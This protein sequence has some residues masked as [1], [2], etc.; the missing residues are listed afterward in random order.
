MSCSSRSSSSSER[1]IRVR[2]AISAAKP[3]PVFTTGTIALPVRSPAYK[4]ASALYM[5]M[6]AAFS[7]FRHAFSEAW[8]SETTYRRTVSFPTRLFRWDLP[9]HHRHVD[10]LRPSPKRLDRVHDD[11]EAEEDQRERDAR[12]VQV[13]ERRLLAR[14]ERV[15]DRLEPG[16]PEQNADEHRPHD[17]EYRKPG[18]PGR[19]PEQVP[20]RE[21]ADEGVDP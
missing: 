19:V 11:G 20:A 16:K 18:S 10:A 6:R 17:P 13:V 5:P 3:S 7:I 14:A 9:V 8:M 15:D 12:A 21:R 2:P 1:A 4:T